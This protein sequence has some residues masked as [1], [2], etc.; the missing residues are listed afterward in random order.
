MP[1]PLRLSSKASFDAYL[2][3]GGPVARKR[4]WALRD[5]LR[6]SLKAKWRSTTFYALHNAS[7]TSSVIQSKL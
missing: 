1:P 7:T 4:L 5:L 2:W 3:L 6:T